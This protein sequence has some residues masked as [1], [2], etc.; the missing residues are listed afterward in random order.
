MDT[1]ND[2]AGCRGHTLGINRSSSLFKSNSMSD[3]YKT[4]T[5]TQGLHAGTFAIPAQEFVIHGLPAGQTVLREAERLGARRV[6]LISG[7]SLGALSDGPLQQVAQALGERHAGTFAAVRAHSPRVDVVA[8]AA[9]AR[10]A[11]ADL[12]VGVGG[13]S[14]IDAAKAVLLCLWLDIT[15]AA[16]MEPYRDGADASVARPIVPPVGA[17]RMLS[18]STTL[19]APEFTAMAGIT[20]THH[21]GSTHGTH[22]THTKQRF[23]HRLMVPCTAILDP[24]ATLLTPLDLLFSTAI[25]SVDHA[26][27][28]WCSP[29]ATPATEAQSLQGLTLLAQALPALQAQP[30]DLWPRMQAQFGMW[31]AVAALAAGVQTGASHGIGYALG[32]GF[33]V[34]HGHTSCVMLPAVLRWN[35]A[36]GDPTIVKRQQALSAAMGQPDQPAADLVAA[37]IGQLGQPTTLRDVGLRED[38]LQALAQAALKFPP[39]LANPRPIRTV[40]DVREILAL[41]W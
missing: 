30:Q 37:L 9:A 18:V 31:Q 19:S 2:A 32:A 34:A 1:P 4:Q 39:V 16:G 28:C 29:M 27:E 26:V 24:G 13:G 40:S 11:G 35:A 15:S 12:L 36:G 5:Q 41:A 10:A 6:F 33:E 17:I 23:A 3:A 8:A 7:R 20:H 14:A 22:T 25:R 38:Q 21:D